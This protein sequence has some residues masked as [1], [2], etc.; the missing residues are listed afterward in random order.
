LLCLH[1]KEIR[2][3]NDLHIPNL[4]Q[5]QQV[6]IAGHDIVRFS[7]QGAVQNLVVGRVFR[8]NL[9]GLTRLNGALGGL[10]SGGTA[11]DCCRYCCG[12]SGL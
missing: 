10:A 2:R 11:S 3:L 9:H 1:G 8:P 6:L 5:I 7:G 12:T 4:S